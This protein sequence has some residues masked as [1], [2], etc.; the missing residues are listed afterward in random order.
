MGLG[1]RM[2]SREEALRHGLP[3]S[4][5]CQCSIKM[6]NESRHPQRADLCGPGCE[7][8]KGSD[9]GPGGES[10]S[11]GKGAFE[12]GLNWALKDG[13]IRERGALP[14]GGCEE[15]HEG[16][17]ETAAAAAQA[18]SAPPSRAHAPPRPRLCG[19][20]EGDPGSAPT[21]QGCPLRQGGQSGSVM[22]HRALG[23]G[24]SIR[25]SEKTSRELRGGARLGP[26]PQYL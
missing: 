19:G 15:R 11:V 14:P 2:G 13:G 26:H 20:W 12:V 22:V 3:S 4:G 24:P 1:R 23:L 21:V 10:W 18:H 17:R 7:L 25:D 8:G 16:G 5:C 6:S 9:E